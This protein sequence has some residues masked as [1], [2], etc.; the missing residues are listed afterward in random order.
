MKRYFLLLPL[1]VSACTP[2][3]MAVGAGASL[4]SAAVQERGLGGAVSDLGIQ[5]DI[6]GKWA[7]NNLQLFRQL[8]VTVHEGRV[9]LTGSVDDAL[10][11]LEAVKLVWQVAGVKEVINEIR[12]NEPGDIADTARDAWISTQLRAA[13]TFD[14][15]IYAVNYS[16]D[17]V[18]GVVYLMGVAQNQEELDR[19]IA[20]ARAIDYVR[21][22]ISYVRL[23]QPPGAR[24]QTLEKNSLAPDSRFPIC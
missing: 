3:G 2:A 4:G 20:H 8:N 14:K 24:G 10:T 12:V 15:N 16:I 7:D 13:L 1:L 11:R 6:A 21:R 23:K 22:V 5:A 18:K 9:L 17:T 19:A